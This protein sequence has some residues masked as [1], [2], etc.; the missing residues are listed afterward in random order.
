MLLQNNLQINKLKLKPST[1]KF[2]QFGHFQFLRTW[3]NCKFFKAVDEMEFKLPYPT[4]LGVGELR[5]LRSEALNDIRAF[6][7]SLPSSTDA[8]VTSISIDVG[9]VVRADEI[10]LVDLYRALES[11]H[12]SGCSKLV[13]RGTEGWRPEGF[14]F[15]PDAVPRSLELR[16]PPLEKL[17][18]A[19]SIFFSAPVAPCLYRFFSENKI[20]D[21]ELEYSR[22]PADDMS[23][24]LSLCVTTALKSLILHDARV[25]DIWGILKRNP[26]LEMI[27]VQH[28][29]DPSSTEH[30]TPAINTPIRL[31]KLRTI[32]STNRALAAILPSF[33]IPRRRC[34]PL[35]RI[36]VNLDRDDYRKV[37]DAEAGASAMQ[38]MSSYT[39]GV[40]DLVYDIAPFSHCTNPVFPSPLV[41]AVDTLQ[42]YCHLVAISCFDTLLASMVQWINSFRGLQSF[43]LYLPLELYDE[44]ACAEKISVKTNRPTKDI[45]AID[46]EIRAFNEKQTVRASGSSTEY[47]KSEF[48]QEDENDHDA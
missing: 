47:S 27:E 11:I 20:K 46:A 35:I 25:S 48:K 10:D 5:E 21:L 43:V 13:L 28:V 44:G 18:V 40:K 29:V 30:P 22:L 16:S 42:V 33:I 17:F 2:K 6:F 32:Y 12:K 1:F 26:L 8:H 15:H 14:A 24:F 7:A 31:P 38:L 19:G 9:H 34:Q 23:N 45:K 39:Q 3:R 37:F 4:D 41:L 36:Q